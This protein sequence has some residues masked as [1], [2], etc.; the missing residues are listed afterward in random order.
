LV[1]GSLALVAACASAPPRESLDEP[2]SYEAELEW[3]D[4]EI[5]TAA[6]ERLIHLL[7]TRATLTAS[8][9]DR[10]RL[11]DA[12]QR[13]LRAS[14]AAE[15]YLY[16]A[17]LHVELHRLA[18]ALDDLGNLSQWEERSDQTRLLRAD[19]AL[20]QGRYDEA[21]GGYLRLLAQERTWDRLARV[22]YMA[23]MDGDG[24]LADSLYAEAQAG[25]TAK[26]LRT[27]AWLELQRGLLD[28]EQRRY[29]AALGHYRHAE[30]AYS[31]WWLVQ[32]HTAEVLAR[33]GLSSEA[34][35]LYE[36]VIA[37]TGSPAHLSALARVRSRHDPIEGERL[38]GRADV[39]FAQHLARYPEATLGS[40]VKHL[41]ARD[42]MRR[43]LVALAERN[44]RLRPN[45][46]SALL[47]AEACI[48]QGREARARA[49][50]GDLGR[51]SP[52]TTLRIAEL[53][54]SLERGAGTQR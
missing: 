4:R 1:I 49:L 26:Q 35:T 13:A 38:Y 30:R 33:L 27:F 40:W 29:R 10:A 53:Q 32:E 36:R 51:S 14:P 3:I 34:A 9:G 24:P 25:L 48:R 52:W 37:Q 31:G 41:L 23:W 19:V 43:D 17:S 45:A 44:H 42:P 50:L 6:R 18:A 2:S 47:L 28:F 5:V 15:L 39:L 20:Q 21:R 8:L 7:W 12:I 46:E 16:R 54:R 11:E 22:A